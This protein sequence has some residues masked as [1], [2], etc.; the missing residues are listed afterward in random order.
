MSDSARLMRLVLEIDAGTQPLSGWLEDPDELRV[1]FTGLLEL[2]AALDRT[3]AA[4]PP[5]GPEDTFRG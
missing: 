5:A 3:L 1:S 2:L 4:P